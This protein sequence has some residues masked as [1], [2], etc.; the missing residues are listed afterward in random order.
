MGLLRNLAIGVFI[1]GLGLGYFLGYY[2][3]T[4]RR[5][6]ITRRDSQPYLVDKKESQ[7]VQVDDFMFLG[8]EHYGGSDLGDEL[9][10]RGL[11]KVKNEVGNSIDSL[12]G[13]E[14][15]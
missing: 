10:R 9:F 1:G 5:Y 14:E 15:P 2:V 4:D 11:N 12:L 13:Y 3:N 6:K 8:A 7:F